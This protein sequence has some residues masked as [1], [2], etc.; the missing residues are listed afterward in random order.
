MRV[1]L[2]VRIEALYRSGS[3]VDLGEA[4]LGRAVDDLTL[5]I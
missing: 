5:K 3:A 1:D 4:D 2:H